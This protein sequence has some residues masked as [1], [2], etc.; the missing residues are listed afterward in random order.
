MLFGDFIGAIKNAAG[1][2]AFEGLLLLYQC[3]IGKYDM[4]PKIIFG[5]DATS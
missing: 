4:F 5:L 1:R 2:A 3:E